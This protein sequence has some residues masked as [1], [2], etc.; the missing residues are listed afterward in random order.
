MVDAT[1]PEETYKT[2]IAMSW[3]IEGLARNI[4]NLKHF[5]N[6]HLPDLVFISEP[7]IFQH[8]I[9]LDMMPL[10]GEYNFSVNSADKFDPEL[11][12]VRS[13]AHGGTNYGS[14]EV[15]P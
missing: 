14:V 6:I 13:R 4:Y 8:D 7:M 11:P 12:L 5:I 3:N 2:F 15:V 9:D 10:R 1:E